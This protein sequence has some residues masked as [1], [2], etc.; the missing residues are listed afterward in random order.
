MLITQ[1]AFYR[2][3]KPA[4]LFPP[5][6]KGNFQFPTRSGMHSASMVI[7]HLRLSTISPDGPIQMLE[8]FLK[9][10]FPNQEG[11]KVID[12]PFDLGTV[13]T[14]TAYTKFANEQSAIITRANATNVL[15]VISDHSNEKGDLYL[16]QHRRKD[17]AAK[18]VEVYPFNS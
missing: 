13:A 6:I 3:G 2:D 10:Y 12:I 11:F 14:T 7:V 4:L 1:Q 15:F 8:N 18:V 17:V 16:G 9:R 5:P